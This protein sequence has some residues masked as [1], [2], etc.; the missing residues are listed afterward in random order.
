M[1]RRH[2]SGDQ[3]KHARDVQL[4]HDVT[5]GARP[6]QMIHPTHRK[7]ED[8]RNDHDREAGRADPT[9][10]ASPDEVI[11]H[12]GKNAC[13]KEM[14]E[15]IHGLPEAWNAEDIDVVHT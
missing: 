8:G 9:P 10:T 2:R 4:P 12:D 13:R 1:D 11:P 6:Q 14:G 5:S 3:R 7:Q 15:A